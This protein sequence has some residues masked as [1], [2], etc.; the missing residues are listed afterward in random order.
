MTTNIHAP[1]NQIRATTYR[2]PFV[3]IVGVIGFVGGLLAFLAADQAFDLTGGGAKTQIRVTSS[4]R[5][6][7]ESQLA[8]SSESST[9]LSSDSISKTSTVPLSTSLQTS[10]LIST[11]SYSPSSSSSSSRSSNVSSSHSK[12]MMSA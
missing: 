8:S 6:Q 11:A 10:S 5:M 2:L 12:S 4:P 3:I 1:F 7:L 9:C